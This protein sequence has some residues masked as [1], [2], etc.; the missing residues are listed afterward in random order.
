MDITF[1]EDL[2]GLLISGHDDDH[3]A[4]VVSVGQWL[5]DS[6]GLDQWDQAETMAHLKLSRVWWHQAAGQV[7]EGYEADGVAAE[8]VVIAI[9]VGTI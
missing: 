6:S 3:P 2:G 7:Y 1:R 4:V 5:A 9:G 8:R